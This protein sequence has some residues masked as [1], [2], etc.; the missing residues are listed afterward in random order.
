MPETFVDYLEQTMAR[1]GMDAEQFAEA[2]GLSPSVVFRWHRAGY[3]PNVG[4][5]RKFA[6]AA[7]VPLLEVLV[8]AD[9]ITEAEARAYCDH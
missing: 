2:C 9:H 8:A 4:N 5:A 3:V 7:G 1:L 6:E